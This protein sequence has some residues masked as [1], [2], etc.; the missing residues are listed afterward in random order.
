MPA[1]KSATARTRMSFDYRAAARAAKI[2][3][4]ALRTLESE[5]ADEFPGDPMLMELHILR[6]VRAHGGRRRRG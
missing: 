1:T 5:A 4:A 6:A 2:S 3:P